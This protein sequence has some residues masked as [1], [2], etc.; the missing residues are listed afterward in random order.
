MSSDKTEAPTGQ[1]LEKAREE[2]QVG[3]STELNTAII[4]LASVSLLQGPGL[5][6]VEAMRTILVHSL[7]SLPQAELTEASLGTTYLNDLNLLIPGMA[8][9]LLGFALI[10]SVVTLAQTRFLWAGKLMGFKFR[11][12]R[13]NPIKNLKRIFS[14]HGLIELGRAVLKLGVVGWMAYGSAG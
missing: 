9:L 4:M 14:T 7:T 12:S 3:V 10:G 2:G 5:S 1:R 6:L 8:Y 11:A 13:L